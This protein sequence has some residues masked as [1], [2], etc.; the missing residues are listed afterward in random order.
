MGPPSGVL[1]GVSPT[2]WKPKDVANTVLVDKSTARVTSGQRISLSSIESVTAQ[3][4]DGLTYYVYEH[5]SQ[6]GCGGTW[7]ALSHNSIFSY[8]CSLSCN[9]VRSLMQPCTL[10][11]LTQQH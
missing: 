9:L 6:V 8:S 5:V 7:K 2:D 4:R 3:Q 10:H 1:K 11:S